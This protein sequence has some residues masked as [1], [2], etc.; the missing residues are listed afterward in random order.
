MINVRQ[1]LYDQGVRSLADFAKLKGKKIGVG[2]VGSIN[3]YNFARACRRPGSIPPRTCSGPSTW[4][5]RT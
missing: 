4:R 3:Q 2:A 5:S 1:E